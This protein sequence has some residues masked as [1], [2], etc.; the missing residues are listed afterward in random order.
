MGKQAGFRSLRTGRGKNTVSLVVQRFHG[1]VGG[2]VISTLSKILLV[3]WLNLFYSLAHL[4]NSSV[5]FVAFMSTFIEII[6]PVV[7]LLHYPF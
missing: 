3:S 7:V 6:Q 1:D 2:F 4:C 5:E